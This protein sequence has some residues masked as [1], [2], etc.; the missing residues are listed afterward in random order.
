MS[1]YIEHDVDDDTFTLAQRN[2]YDREPSGI[3]ATRDEVEELFINLAAF[4]GKEIVS[5]GNH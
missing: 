3:F 5:L 1:I 4:L 2:T